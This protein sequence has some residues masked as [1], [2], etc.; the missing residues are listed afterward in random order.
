[1]HPNAIIAVA[2]SKNCEE[3]H[4]KKSFMATKWRTCRWI[5]PGFELGLAMQEIATKN[6][7]T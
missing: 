3:A 5:R 7:G 2:A 1:M 4:R 6:P